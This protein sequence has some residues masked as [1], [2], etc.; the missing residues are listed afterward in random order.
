MSETSVYVAEGAAESDVESIVASI[1][2]A[3]YLAW[4]VESGRTAYPGFPMVVDLFHRPDEELQQWA[5]QIK[6]TIIERFGVVV[7]TEREIQGEGF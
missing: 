6:N 7:R 5:D 2:P 4:D 3:D 1:V